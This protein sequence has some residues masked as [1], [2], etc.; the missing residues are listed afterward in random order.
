MKKP[1]DLDTVCTG[2]QLMDVSQDPTSMYYAQNNRGYDFPPMGVA[3]HLA[4]GAYPMDDVLECDFAEL[5]D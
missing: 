2:L 4:A 1:S 5:D 3:A